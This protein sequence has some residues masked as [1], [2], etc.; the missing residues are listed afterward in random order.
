MGGCGTDTVCGGGVKA[1]RVGLGL[2]QLQPFR[3]VASGD[4]AR[5]VTI[6]KRMINAMLIFAL[7]SH[8]FIADFGSIITRLLFQ[9]MDR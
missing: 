5:Q 7:M 1:G 8:R 4:Q 3:V 6:W 2:V 9:L